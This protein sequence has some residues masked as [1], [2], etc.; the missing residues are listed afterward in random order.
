MKTSEA[1]A[2]VGSALAGG[3]DNMHPDT[4]RKRSE[5]SR[6]ERINDKQHPEDK[7]H[8]GAT[9]DEVT[10]TTPPV[11]PEYEDEPKQG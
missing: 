3:G 7:E 4:E 6:Q 8:E 10:P 2:V 9:E 11:S 5:H 1:S